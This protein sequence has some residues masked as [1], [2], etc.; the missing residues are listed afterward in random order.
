[1]VTMEIL[2]LAYS[3]YVPNRRDYFYGATQ[4]SNKNLD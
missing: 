3:L 4:V 2:Q 1:M